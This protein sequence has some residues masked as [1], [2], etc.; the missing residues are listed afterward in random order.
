MLAHEEAATDLERLRAEHAALRER[1]DA[2]EVLLR[3]REEEVG[4]LEAAKVSAAREGCCGQWGGSTCGREGGREGGGGA[5]FTN[6]TDKEHEGL[7]TAAQRTR[8]R[9]NVG[10]AASWALA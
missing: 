1:N 6:S 2:M 4:I 7:R 8:L 9:G 3:V 5:G 10:Q